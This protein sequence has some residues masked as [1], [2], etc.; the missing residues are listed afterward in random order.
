MKQLFTTLFILIYFLAHAQ[1]IER[2]VVST[3]GNFYSN[4]AGQ[5]ST[6]LG[7]PIIS[8]T[9]SGT[10]EL[11][12]GF[13]QTKTTVTSIED[14]QTDFEM[15]VYPNP[16]SEY[17]IIKIEKIKEDINFTIYTIEGKIIINNQLKELETK[18]DIGGFAKGSYFLNITEQ[19]KIIKTYKIIKQ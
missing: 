1:T 18:L 11:T 7:E 13:Q 16:V 8:T 17:I 15:N 12:Q 3:S 14:Y 2:E 4:S 10:N 9:S 6:T 5:L 19:N